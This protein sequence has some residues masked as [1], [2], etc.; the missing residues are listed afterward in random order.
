M[1]K[2]PIV[3]RLRDIE[4]R[5]ERLLWT[6]DRLVTT[7]LPMPITEMNGKQAKK[8]FRKRRK[9]QTDILKLIQ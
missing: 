6:V 3:S 9:L 4:T 8:Y 2:H 1:P 5:E 7:L